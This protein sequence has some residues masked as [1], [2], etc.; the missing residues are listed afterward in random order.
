MKRFIFVLVGI[1]ALSNSTHAA[2]Q[3]GRFVGLLRHEATQRDQMAKID[4]ITSRTINNQLELKAVLNLY[5]GDFGSH[6]YVSYHFDYV[7]YDLVTGELVFDQSDQDLTLKTVKFG[8]GYLNAQVRSNLGGEL[9]VLELVED[10]KAVPRNPL[11]TSL[12]GEFESTCDGKE[13]KLQIFTF[14]SAEELVR[15][16]N[17]FGAYKIRAQLAEKTIVGSTNPYLVIN[18][19]AEGTYNFF[20]DY[21]NLFG[22]LDNLECR[23]VPDSLKC[24]SCEFKRVPASSTID[25]PRTSKSQIFVL[26]SSG[27]SSLAGGYTG[28]LHH[29]NLN[30]YQKASINVVTY[31]KPDENG[32][33]S[34]FI[35][36]VAQLH[37]GDYSSQET[38]A[39]RFEARKYDLLNSSFVLSRTEDDVDAILKIDRI[40][41][42]EVRGEWYSIIFGR[43][44][45]FVLRKD[46]NV[47][48]PSR[49]LTLGKSS[50][51]YED[52]AIEVHLNARLSHSPINT[53]NPFSPLVFGGYTYFKG[54]LSKRLTITGGSYDFYTGAFTILVDEKHWAGSGRLG[55]D[56]NLYLAWP[57][58]GFLT[59]LQPFSERKLDLR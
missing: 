32:A 40:E 27:S 4:F 6:E 29:E 49:S 10:G 57:S 30:R 54:G 5:F 20:S 43:V 50:G 45:T 23:V 33:N 36:V 3:F 41:N 51:I 8:S 16:G 13:K 2:S 37:F 31:Q 7:T 9:G 58:N 55:D 11:I 42:G 19:F 53:E 56:K 47:N 1:L 38:L 46:G 18:Q 22:D 25:R 21:L 14:R 59:L 15:Q 12:Q 52:K 39:Y 17:P 28:Y 44:G 26:G 35:S 48:I 24:G 34:L